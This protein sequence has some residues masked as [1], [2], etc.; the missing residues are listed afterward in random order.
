MA[1][2]PPKQIGLQDAILLFLSE[3]N[4]LFKA[5]H[6]IQSAILHST[7]ER[8]TDSQ[9]SGILKKLFKANKIDTVLLDKKQWFKLHKK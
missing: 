5:R 8:Y 9:I 4:N 3:D 7:G 2:F 6:T 1:M